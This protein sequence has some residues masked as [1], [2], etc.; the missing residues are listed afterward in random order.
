M[1]KWAGLLAAE[2]A[3]LYGFAE[4]SVRIMS[5]VKFLD[6]LVGQ[7]LTLSI[8]CETIPLIGRSFTQCSEL[9]CD[10]Y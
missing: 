1:T 3:S 10:K 5:Y 9:C 8:A 7:T 2:A 6:S 4:L